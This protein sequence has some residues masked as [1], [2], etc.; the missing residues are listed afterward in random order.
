[1]QSTMTHKGLRAFGYITVLTLGLTLGAAFPALAHNVST[2]GS[3]CQTTSRSAPA[4][5]TP[6]P[7]WSPP[8]QREHP[9]PGPF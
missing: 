9:G 3:S 8:P 2:G 1:M 4:T 7:T 6:D 5:S